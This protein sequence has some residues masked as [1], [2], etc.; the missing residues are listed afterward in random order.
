MSMMRLHR[1]CFGGKHEEAQ[2]HAIG[3]AGRLF[4]HQTH[5]VHGRRTHTTSD[6]HDDE[7][8]AEESC[9]RHDPSDFYYGQMGGGKLWRLPMQQRQTSL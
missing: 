3:R 4:I 5:V 7:Y 8:Q 9:K 1:A 2:A 6:L